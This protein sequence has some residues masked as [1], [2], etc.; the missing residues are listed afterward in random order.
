[1][2]DILNRVRALSQEIHDAG[3]AQASLAV[4]ISAISD[5]TAEDEH[6]A[7]ADVVFRKFVTEP[8]ILEASEDLFYSGHYNVAV[9]NAVKAVEVYIKS[10][11]PALSKSGTAL[12][13]EVFSTSSPRLVWS[14]RA[15]QSEKDEH[16]GYRSLFAGIMLGVR[17]PTT[18]EFGWIAEADDALECILFAQHLL[19]KAKSAVT[20]T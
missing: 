17:N 18:H 13:Y 9:F 3:L 12:M 6:T 15:S 20:P 7:A 5:A 16:D 1:M 14:N 8:E 4:P 10:R 11:V 2:K 19:K